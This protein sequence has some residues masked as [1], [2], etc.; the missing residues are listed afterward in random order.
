MSEF[1]VNSYS[2]TPLK[3][4][5]VVLFVPPT[6]QQAFKARQKAARQAVK[7]WRQAEAVVKQAVE[8]STWPGVSGGLLYKALSAVGDARQEADEATRK[9]R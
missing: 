5:K 4:V 9:W 8:S 1:S 7:L 2:T 3:G 6:P